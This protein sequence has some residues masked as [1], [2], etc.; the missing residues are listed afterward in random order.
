MA[1][2]VFADTNETA[3]GD[4]NALA[5]SSISAGDKYSCVLLSDGSAKCWGQ[6]TDGQLGDG[7]TTN[8]STPVVVSTLSGATAISV[9]GNHSCALLSGGTVECW[10]YNAYGQLGDGTT[11]DRST[12]VV[13]SSLSGVTA[14]AIGAA[15]SCALLS[16]G[17]V[18][19]WGLNTYGQLGNGTT[20][21]SS[22]PV[23][24]SSLSGVRSISL[25]VEHTCALLSAGTVNCWGRNHKGQLGNGTTSNS[26]TPVEVVSSLGGS[27]LSG[28]TSLSLGV[29]HSCVLLST[30]TV[31]CW[32]QNA[33]GHLGDGT[34]SNSSTP[35]EVVLSLGGSSLSGVTAVSLGSRHSCALLT[36]GTVKCWGWNDIGQL[37][38]GT[39][40]DRSTPVSVLLLSGVGVTT[41]TTTTTTTAPAGAVAPRVPGQVPPWPEAVVSADGSVRVSWDV[42]FQ[43]GAGPITGYRVVSSPSGGSCVT[44]PFDADPL[45]CVVAGLELDV[46]YLFEVFASNGVGEGPG[47]MTQQ[48]V[49]IV[50]QAPDTT[51]PET[52]VESVPA[53]TPV[54]GDSQPLPVTGSDDGL[55]MWSLLLVAFG[56]FMVV[57]VRTA[58]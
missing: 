4:T 52:T 3:V 38:D 47:R 25:G 41:T 48:A 29:D 15:H 40:T 20:A 37:G 27:S 17:T 51:V 16:D 19:C 45:S 14:I 22:T 10:G 11:I 46:D 54:A 31:N 23:A 35:V 50:P 49:R 30:G 53:T 9:G 6:N 7:T 43:D 5:Q 13:V 32:G 8:R 44:S 36:G 24:V 42:P 2:G 1:V 18:K 33:Y 21:S 28:S 12:P 57:R 56:A 26:S 34:T 58:R 39:T 55:V